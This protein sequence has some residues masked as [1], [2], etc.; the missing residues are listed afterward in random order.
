MDGFTG[1]N[2][3]GVKITLSEFHTTGDE[4]SHRISIALH[5]FYDI[6]KDNWTSPV[7]VQFEDNFYDMDRCCYNLR[8]SYNNVCKK[9]QDAYNYHA[10]ANGLPTMADEFEEYEFQ[11]DG[12]QFGDYS[13]LESKDGVVGMN[14]N[15]IETAR[16][17]FFNEVNAQ[18]ENIYASY[19]KPAFYDESNDQ[20]SSFV[21]MVVEQEEKLKETFK[22]ALDTLNEKINEE[23]MKVTESVVKSTETLSR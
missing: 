6:V 2:P 13:L 11:P 1:M 16:D 17:T 10:N 5:D 22:T 9:I 4:I 23:K 19:H 3:E 18:I 15:V 8:M 21:S 7:A 14:I 12:A 20:V